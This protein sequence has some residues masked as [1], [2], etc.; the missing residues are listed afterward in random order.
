MAYPNWVPSA[1]L[2][3]A[4]VLIQRPA[5]VRRLGRQ[6]LNTAS[7][8]IQL[9]Y[10]ASTSQSRLF[11]YSICSYSTP[12]RAGNPLPYCCLNTASVLIQQDMEHLCRL[13]DRV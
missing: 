9:M 12:G 3:T 8:L 6:S 10:L 7:V 5:P 2:N 11:K 13:H 4:S 1:S